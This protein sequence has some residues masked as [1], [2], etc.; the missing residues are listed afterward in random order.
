MGQSRRE[1]VFLVDGVDFDSEMIAHQTR[2]NRPC[3]SRRQPCMHYCQVGT[4]SCDRCVEN[5][6]ASLSLSASARPSGVVD[7]V[8]G[9][10]R[11]LWALR[12]PN[13]IDQPIQDITH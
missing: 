13:R 3:G 10:Q 6:I 11:V 8:G 4:T 7:C 2:V 9:P 5:D 12:S 1:F